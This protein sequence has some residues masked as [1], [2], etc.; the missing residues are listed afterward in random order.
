MPT[1]PKR[2]FAIVIA[3][4]LPLAAAGAARGDQII[5]SNFGPGMTFD[6]NRG[7]TIGGSGSPAPSVIA[8]RFTATSNLAFSSAQLALGFINGP[9]LF[10]VLL[11]TDAGGLP[12][13]IIETFNVNIQLFPPGAVVTA[14]S[15]LNPL[16]TSGA[17]Y[18]LV[19]YAP[20]SST[21]GEWNLS[22]DDVPIVGNFAFNRIPSPTG[23]WGLAS[24]PVRSAFQINGNTPVPEPATLLLLGPGLAVL[25]LRGSRCKTGKH[26]VAKQ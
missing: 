9:G 13:S 6:T 23:P 4:V 26:G 19:V 17:N 16:L 21:F 15:A 25:A 20:G 1:F 3:A 14:I 22:L 12:G 7:Y 5:F 11:E 18:W 2:L 8:N 10:Q 24:G